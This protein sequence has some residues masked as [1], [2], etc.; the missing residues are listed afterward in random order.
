MRSELTELGL[1]TIDREGGTWLV[2]DPTNGYMR[3]IGKW[4][5]KEAD[6]I[7]EVGIDANDAGVGEVLNQQV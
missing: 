1:M 4:S 5:K 7:K 6:L 3:N 2:L